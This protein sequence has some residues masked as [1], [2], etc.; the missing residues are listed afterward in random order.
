[1]CD[2]MT[3]VYRF[4]NDIILLHVPRWAIK[5][6]FFCWQLWYFN[7]HS[8]LY[9]LPSL[10]HTGS[11]CSEQK[12]HSQAAFPSL[13]IQVAAK[14]HMYPLHGFESPVQINVRNIYRF[15]WDGNWNSVRVNEGERKRERILKMY[16]RHSR[17]TE[18]D[19]FMLSYGTM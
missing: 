5:I 3:C 10:P 15:V 12:G 4:N 19:I 7:L 8:L 13:T 9:V 1:V 11:W 17:T 16:R 6:I 18:Y 14:L 2:Y